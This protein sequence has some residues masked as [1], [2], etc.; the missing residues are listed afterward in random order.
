MAKGTIYESS[1]SFYVRYS[2]GMTVSKNGKPRPI[3]KSHRLCEKN[4]KYYSSKARAVKL[5]RDAFMLTVNTRQAR[6]VGE[7][8][9]IAAFWDYRYVPYCKET[10][11]L[12][13]RPR[14]KPSTIRGY[15]QIWRQH[16]KSHFGNITLQEYEAHMGTQFL[17]SLT[18]TQGKAT[19]KHIK[20]L[21]GS[22]FKRAVIERRVRS[23]R[24]MTCRCQTTL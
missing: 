1:G 4:D 17:Q 10:L 19:L 21:G 15:E 20:A 2:V 24:G 9:T 12:T 7:D 18:S 8:M 11:Q 6:T 16:L 22:I 13:G 23:V 14:K 5:L 3:Q